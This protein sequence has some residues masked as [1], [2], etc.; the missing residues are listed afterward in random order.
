VDLPIVAAVF[1]S[2]ALLLPVAAAPAASSTTTYEDMA[3][4]LFRDYLRIDTSNP[5]GNELAAAR[6]F[7]RILDDEGIPAE[8]DEFAPGRANLLATLEATASPRKRPLL[9]TSHMDVVP[10]DPARWSVAPFSGDSKDGSLYG[11]GAVDMKCEGILQLVALIR[12]KREGGPLDRDVLFLATADEEVDYAGATRALSPEGWG[13]RLRRCELAIAEGGENPVGPD[14]RP[15]YFGVQTAQKATF[16]LR[17]STTGTPGHGSRPTGESAVTRLVR[18]LE[19]IRLYR[20]P[21]KVLP[22]VERQFRDEAALAPAPQ[23]EWYRDIRTALQDPQKARVI[24]SGDPG[25]AAL[26]RNTIAITVVKAGYKT[27]VIPGTAEAELDVRLLPGESRE[28]FRAELEKVIGDPDVTI[29][30]LEATFY[31]PSDVPID[32]PLFHAIEEVLHRRYPG[33]PVMTRMS[34]GATENSLYRPL[35]IASYG[36]TPLVTTREEIDSQHG[37]DERLR[38]SAFR[39]AV[40]PLY[41]VVAAVAGR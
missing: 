38:E 25:L 4:S 18:A 36:F 39:E 40:L 30:P 16:W 22:S 5:P 7:K 32:T 28:A 24:E 2:H 35:G 15:R 3:V 37:D 17:L 19:R 20:P 14:G 31:P 13:D 41:E 12:L 21:F 6:F 33:V 27:N 11:R 29:T 9:L 34:T 26:L 8:I 1:V 23:S 10:A